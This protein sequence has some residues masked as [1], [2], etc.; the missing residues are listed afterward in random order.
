MEEGS[1]SKMGG[2]KIQIHILNNFRVHIVTP[3][4]HYNLQCVSI[5]LTF[6]LKWPGYVTNSEYVP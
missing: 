2:P 1:C 4:L 6:K 5:D 3:A